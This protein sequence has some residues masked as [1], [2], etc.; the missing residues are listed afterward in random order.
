MAT[1][2]EINL[3]EENDVSISTQ[4]TNSA[5]IGVE[6]D[7]GGTTDYTKLKNKPSINGVTLQSNKT[8]VELG[9]QASEEG[10]GLSTN[11]FT[12]SFKEKLKGL[13]NYDDT[14]IKKYIDETLGNITI[15]LDIVNGEVI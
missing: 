15:V 11:D 8:L 6:S 12:D 10:K 9:I 1:E 3:E 5:E 4:S 7:F 13:E 2:I 14:G